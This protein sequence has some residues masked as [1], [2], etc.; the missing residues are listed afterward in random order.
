M[1]AI[2]T[3]PWVYMASTRE[4]GKLLDIKGLSLKCEVTWKS[5]FDVQFRKAFQIPPAR[6]SVEYSPS[7]PLGSPFILSSLH[8]VPGG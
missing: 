3:K 1:A 2:L 5:C 6:F 4:Q 7:V 8:C